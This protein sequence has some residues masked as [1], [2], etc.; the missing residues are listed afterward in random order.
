MSNKV[1]YNRC[2]EYLQDQHKQTLEN[3]HKEV[4]TLK[5]DN[6]KL[7][8]KI[9]V[10]ESTN[11]DDVIKSSLSKTRVNITNTNIPSEILLQETIKDLKVKL[12]L[13]DDTNSHLN[14]TIRNLNKK[15]NLL[16]RLSKGP[17]IY[18][19]KPPEMNTNTVA[20]QSSSIPK[21]SS[22]HHTSSSSRRGLQYKSETEKDVIINKLRMSNEGQLKKIEELV[23]II[24]DYDKRISSCQCGITH[25]LPL[26][27]AHHPVNP[28]QNQVP[29]CNNVFGKVNGHVINTEH[30]GI[31]SKGLFR[32]GSQDRNGFGNAGLG[33]APEINN[34]GPRL[35]PLNGSCKNKTA[36][37]GLEQNVT[38]P[39]SSRMVTPRSSRVDI[40]LRNQ[41]RIQQK[42]KRE[43]KDEKFGLGDYS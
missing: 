37:E 41:K 25:G 7:Q 5:S 4:H 39:T 16:K 28:V 32:R 14:S 6:Q 27:N 29:A 20:R 30:V 43:R 2:L 38:A 11:V 31:S 13:S 10:E 34:F 3:L 42:E 35:P 22:S 24:Q 21:Q 17:A 40:S 36:G 12:K 19:P 18:M 8:F 23:K 15:M 9:L 26:P 33:L 1:H